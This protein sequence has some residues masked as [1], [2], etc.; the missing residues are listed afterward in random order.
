[1]D[2]GYRHQICGLCIRS[3]HPVTILSY[4]LI[5]KMALLG[6]AAGYV[7]SLSARTRLKMFVHSVRGMVPFIAIVFMIVRHW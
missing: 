4:S 7:V 3:K 6:M 5:L 2:T 1:M